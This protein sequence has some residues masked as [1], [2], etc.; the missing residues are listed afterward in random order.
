MFALAVA[1]DKQ[2]FE[3][4]ILGLEFCCQLRTIHFR[5]HD[6]RDE[7]VDPERAVPAQFNRFL[8]VAR[9]KY[10]V[11]LAFRMRPMS[12]RTFGS[13][14]TTRID[15]VPR[16]MAAG[17]ELT[18]HEVRPGATVGKRIR[19]V[20]PWPGWLSTAIWPPASRTISQTVASPIPV[21]FPTGL[22]V[23]NG[24]NMRRRVASSIPQPVSLTASRAY[25]P[26][27]A[28]GKV[29]NQSASRSMVFVSIMLP[30]LRH[31]VARIDDEI[32]QHLFEMTGIGADMAQAG[33]Q[34]CFEF[35]IFADEA[36]EHPFHLRHGRVEI[37]HGR[38][39][40]FL[41][42]KSEELFRKARS[43]LT[44]VDDLD[45]KFASRFIDSVFFQ[46]DFAVAQNDRQHI[47]EVV[48]DAADEPTDCV[49]FLCLKQIIFGV[50]QRLFRLRSP[51]KLSNLIRQGRH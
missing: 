13:S 35:D 24:S 23:K 36:A 25:R 33:R 47:I 41:A 17:A 11:P 44:G 29:F 12:R 2:H 37:Q 32:H 39:G 1:G 48:D 45:E 19:K 3:V 6:V 38:L 18:R 30:P 31:R 20:H 49:H 4:R 43:S 50:P 28:E 8:R 40:G 46:N 7:Q 34:G 22:V 27:T 14:S 15:S 5:H 9:L 21:P 42:T 26:G 10:R 51:Q 16:G